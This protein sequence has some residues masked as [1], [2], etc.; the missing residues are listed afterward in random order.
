MQTAFASQIEAAQHW[1]LDVRVESDDGTRLACWGV[2]ADARASALNTAEALIALD[3]HAALDEVSTGACE[4]MIAGLGDTERCSVRHVAW[5]AAALDLYAVRCPSSE[6]RA[7]IA[8]ALAAAR[9][10]LVAEQRFDGG[11]SGS[12]GEASIV[13]TTALVLRALGPDASTLSRLSVDAGVGWLLRSQN[14]DGGWGLV[15]DYAREYEDVK[16]Q[17][18]SPAEDR[19]LTRLRTESNAACTAYAVLAL[20]EVGRAGGLEGGAI[21]RGAGWLLD[22]REP[23]SIERPDP[24]SGGWPVFH[25]RGIH[26]RRSYTFRHFSTAWAILALLAAGRHPRD[27][28]LLEATEYLLGLA[29]PAVFNREGH[30]I[31]GGGW[32][33]SRDGEPFTWSTSNAILALREAARRIEA[34]SG[35]EVVEIMLADRRSRAA[36]FLGQ[37]ARPFVINARSAHAVGIVT[38]LLAAAV[39]VAAATAAASRSLGFVIAAAAAA[40]AAAPWS[41]WLAVRRDAREPK[42]LVSAGHV[43][44]VVVAVLGVI[45]AAYFG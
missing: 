41:I 11:W 26:G 44:G 31:E 40:I 27:P 13:S 16:G 25:E 9:N 45:G 42:L 33:C 29:Q 43:Y 22:R 17:L 28:V 14:G 6:V 38:T 23:R 32:R 8:G 18:S 35:D 24:S 2:Q 5:I 4:F 15:A 19:R 7:A 10:R 1:L 21:Q 34:L 3:G 30:Q 39:V 37:P 36:S 20:C 12:R